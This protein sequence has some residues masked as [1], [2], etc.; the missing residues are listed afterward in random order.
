MIVILILTGV[1]FVNQRTEYVHKPQPGR[2]IK[3][4]KGVAPPK[5]TELIIPPPLK[6]GPLLESASCITPV[7]YTS[8]E[9]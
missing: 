5:I 8:K 6:I 9:P 4:R 7:D 1:L 3:T 2:L